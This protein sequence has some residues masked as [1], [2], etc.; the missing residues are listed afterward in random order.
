MTATR[1]MTSP[2]EL[3]NKPAL[4][5]ARATMFRTALRDCKPVAADFVFSVNFE[6]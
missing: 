4:D 1:I 3:L 5:A 6:N 2:S